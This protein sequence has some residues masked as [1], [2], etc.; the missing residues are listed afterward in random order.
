MLKIKDNVDLKEL[1][2]FGFVK[3]ENTEK[4]IYTYTI[5]EDGL[6]MECCI[7]VND[8]DNTDRAL[9]FM[10]YNSCDFEEDEEEWIN[11][12]CLIPDIVYNLIQAGI[13]EKI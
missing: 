4:E 12:D 3:T 11:Y 10:Y 5:E 1:E 2:K 6:D 13:V 7:L 8:I 9:R